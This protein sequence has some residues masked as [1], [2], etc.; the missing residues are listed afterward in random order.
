MPPRI[1]R[2]NCGMEDN[3]ETITTIFDLGLYL[4][5]VMMALVVALFVVVAGYEFL[6]TV[7]KNAILEKRMR[8]RMRHV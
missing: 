4:V 6:R 1:D 7:V 8:R 5:G 2:K 3:M